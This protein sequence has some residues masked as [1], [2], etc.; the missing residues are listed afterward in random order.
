MNETLPAT[1]E[2][3]STLPTTP[4]PVVLTQ[5]QELARK[6]FMSW[7][8]KEL[9]KMEEEDNH[10]RPGVFRIFGFAGT[11]KTFFTKHVISEVRKTLKPDLN[12]RYS[13]F[14]GKACLVMTRNGLP[15]ST[16]HSSIY[17][18]V[19]PDKQL[20]AD[21]QKQ[22]KAAADPDT[23]KKIGKELKEAESMGFLLNEDEDAP[24]RGVDLYGLD[25][26]SMVNEE[27]LNDI[28]TFQVPLLVLGD[29][30][31]LPPIEG[32]G[33]LMSAK[34]D[35]F[36]DE[37]MRQ[38]ADNPIIKLSILARGGAYI[39]KLDWGKAKHITQQQTTNDEML[40]ADQILCG[41][42]N[43]RST[44]NKRM[45]EL[46]GREGRYPIPGDKLICLRNNKQ[47][48]IFNGLIC[49]VIKQMDEYDTT[50]QYELEDEMG[51]KFI[52][53]ILRL[54]F[55]EYFTPGVVKEAKWWDMQEGDA[56]DFGYAIT[57]HKAQGSQ[58]DN[59]LLWDDKFFVWDKPN[60]ARWLYTGIT[61]SADKLTIAS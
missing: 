32:T 44:I 12:V 59:V 2:V 48:G 55:D 54:Y 7:Y 5:K 45:R 58:W 42:N 43:T 19:T 51:R 41:K 52:T 16:I 35:I 39:P 60:R 4:P 26:V 57:V 6:L 1:L 8:E 11:G 46:H 30:G 17:K 47:L 13:A 3:A 28:K 20:A 21:L 37:I 34:P 23:R 53:K 31:Q 38:A 50:I 14:S 25:E 27:L 36:L 9:S 49:K 10:Y 24:L 61:R 18:V 22:L 40:A 56:F 29:P 15:A 33:A